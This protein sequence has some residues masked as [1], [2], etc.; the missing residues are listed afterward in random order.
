MLVVKWRS[1]KQKELKRSQ[2]EKKDS[3]KVMTIT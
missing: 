1:Q 2:N 3:Y